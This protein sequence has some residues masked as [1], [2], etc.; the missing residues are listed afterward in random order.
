MMTAREMVRRVTP[1]MKAPAPMRAKAPGSTQD[2]GLGGRNTPGGALHMQKGKLTVLLG[3]GC[4]SGHIVVLSRTCGRPEC[5]ILMPAQTA[6]SIFSGREGS[7]E[8]DLRCLKIQQ[9]QQSNF[10]LLGRDCHVQQE[11]RAPWELALAWQLNFCN[12]YSAK[13]GLRR[14]AHLA[15]P[16]PPAAAKSTAISPTSRPMQ[17]PMRSMGTKRPLEMAEPAAH[18]APP[19]YTPSITIS[20]A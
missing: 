11:L 8:S 20:A 16:W 3:F 14:W 18:T 2:H 15:E 17:E 7:N 9:T 10:S 6:G 5:S 4:I 19:K 12:K 1:P 13:G